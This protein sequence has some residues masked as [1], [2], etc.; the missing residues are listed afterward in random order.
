MYLHGGDWK[1]IRETLKAV[2]APINSKEL[3]IDDNLVLKAFLNSKEIRPQRVTILD[4]AT[5]KQIEE[6]AL[7]TGVIG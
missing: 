5:Q 3:G 2:G 1:R 6:A 4:K 7:V